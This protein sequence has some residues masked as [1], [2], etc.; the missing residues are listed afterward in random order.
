MSTV[1]TTPSTASGTLPAATYS[2]RVSAV[3][4]RYG[5]TVACAE[6]SAVLAATGQVTLSFT[7]PTGPEGS[8]PQLYKVYRATSSGAETLL[9]YVDANVGL[10]A[11]GVT[12]V[13]TTS[14][15]DDGATLTPKNGSTVPATV[16]AAYVGTNSG[17]LPRTTGEDIYLISRTPDNV[18][19]PY[20]RDV[21]PVD[22][23]PTTASPDSL[24]FALV[25]DTTF[26]VRAPKYLGRARNVVATL[27]S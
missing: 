15:L 16:P 5:E 10:S 14:I 25:S 19:R 11:D 7:P 20:V 24:P 6:V 3:I 21:M 13:V 26:A 8:V 17:H 22:V 27:T 12:P 23:Y 18:I 1:T 9:G 4:A 2:Y